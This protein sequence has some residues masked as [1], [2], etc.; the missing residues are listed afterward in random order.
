M[1]R[2]F[3]LTH[4]EST[5]IPR[6]KSL[7][8][9]RIVN[10]SPKLVHSFSLLSQILLKE[11]LKNLAKCTDYKFPLL[12]SECFQSA[13]WFSWLRHSLVLIKEILYSIE[14][15][16]FSQSSQ[17]MMAKK[18]FYFIFL[19]ICRKLTFQKNLFE[20]VMWTNTTKKES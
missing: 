16:K 10:E 17:I 3:Q 12:A 1:H 18:V 7:E 11:I 14:C 8:R 15:I 20:K 2:N 4:C 9:Q 5:A 19:L 13:I 6:Y